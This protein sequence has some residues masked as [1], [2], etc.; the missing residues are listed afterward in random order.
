M[1]SRPDTFSKARRGARGLGA[2]SALAFGKEVLVG[3]HVRRSVSGQGESSPLSLVVGRGRC[4]GSVK[5]C[6]EEKAT[7]V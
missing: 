2:S 3:K 7:S 6:S 4:T 5:V 1:W